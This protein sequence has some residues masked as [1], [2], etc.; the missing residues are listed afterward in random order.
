MRI[1]Y[2][3]ILNWIKKGGKL[4]NLFNLDETALFFKL[5]RSETL[6]SSSVEGKK[7][8]KER[9]TIAII[10]N[11]LGTHKIRPLV[12]G[13]NKKPHCFGRFSI[14]RRG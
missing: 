7:V 14:Q 13:K 5:Q 1:Q 11:S 6:A 8:N 12:I 10:F 4:E 9:L 3:Y 2:K